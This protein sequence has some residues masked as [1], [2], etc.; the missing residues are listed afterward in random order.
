MFERPKNE[1]EL[2]LLEA[3]GV[4][5][6]SRF[7]RKHA[8][9]HEKADM[10][11][12]FEIHRQI[13]QDAWPEIAGKMR[14]VELTI[15]DSDHI[16]PHHTQVPGLV[17]EA[18][19][20]LDRLLVGLSSTES[21]WLEGRELTDEQANTGD[22]IIGIAAWLH[23]RIT[24]IHPF[25]DGNGRA[26]RLAANLILECYGLIGISIKV[27]RENKNRY[28]QALSQIDKMNDLEPLKTLI[29]EGLID[30]LNGVPMFFNKK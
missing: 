9:S 5:R 16:P 20:E 10:D 12:V 4:I 26:A 7:V 24:F 29:Y 15:T 27:E 6:A 17:K 18:R 11:T 25:Q 21:F 30:R 1:E 23:H 14:N 19:E 3:V 8:H 28:R 22:R 2:Q 13:F